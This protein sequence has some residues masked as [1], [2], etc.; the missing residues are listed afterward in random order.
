VR[1][2][3]R[4]GDETRILQRNSSSSLP[5]VSGSS[6]KD[7][8]EDSLTFALHCL[9]LAVTG[10]HVRQRVSKAFRSY[11]CSGHKFAVR[12]CW[13][14][15]ILPMVVGGEETQQI[16]TKPLAVRGMRTKREE[17]ITA[18]LVSLCGNSHTATEQRVTKSFSACIFSDNARLPSCASLTYLQ[19]TTTAAADVHSG[20]SKRELTTNKRGGSSAKVR[21]ISMVAAKKLRRLSSVGSTGGEG[22]WK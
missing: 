21:L 8:L 9:A 5:K 6:S 12:Y 18:C 14:D 17:R 1:L 16:S 19:T 2:V 3:E 11:R 7:P 13:H 20:A 4:P 22:R 15:S 10:L